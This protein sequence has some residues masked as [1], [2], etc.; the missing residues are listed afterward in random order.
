[1]TPTLTDAKP[2][3]Q[4]KTPG[5]WAADG[6]RYD[7]TSWVGPLWPMMAVERPAPWPMYSFERPST[8]L[9]NAVATALNRKGWSDDEIK[10]WL[11]SKGPRWALDNELGTSLEVIGELFARS[12][13][14][15]IKD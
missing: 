15:K 14:E 4:N 8:I 5:E 13:T 11:Q 9:W 2:V 7:C 1:M 6:S 12:I 3:W 10:S